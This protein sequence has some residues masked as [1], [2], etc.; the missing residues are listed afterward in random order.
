MIYTDIIIILTTFYQ[1][2]GNEYLTLLFCRLLIGVCVGINSSIIPLHVK[3]MTSLSNQ[4]S[5]GYFNQLFI[6]IGIFSGFFVSGFIETSWRTLFVLPVLIC[7]SRIVVFGFVFPFDTPEEYYQSGNRVQA[8]KVLLFLDNSEDISRFMKLP[9][10]VEQAS[11]TDTENNG[12][13]K[14]TSVK[15]VPLKPDINY[16]GV[17]LVLS[18]GSQV[19]G[20]N[21]VMGYSSDIFGDIKYVMNITL[22]VI[23]IV[24]CFLFSPLLKMF[25]LTQILLGGI[26]ILISILAGMG[27]LGYFNLLLLMKI[28]V[29]LFVFV[30]AITLGPGVWAALP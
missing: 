16:F 19:S 27:V 10:E 24:C 13:K 22:S 30:F 5:T 2:T 1:L 8:S 12:S 29:L 9:V 4:N 3:Q 14:V 18:L 20:I 23:Q 25:P 15:V 21:A 11:P 26:S 7:L 6:T 28:G 17:G